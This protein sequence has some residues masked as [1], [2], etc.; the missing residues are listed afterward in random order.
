MARGGAVK[1]EASQKSH[2]RPK[3][4]FPDA[5]LSQT[6]FRIGDLNLEGSRICGAGGF[7]LGGGR[8]RK[9]NLR[10]QKYGDNA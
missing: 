9:I 5:R 1:S 3:S 10:V 8:L 6:I 4:N 2:I 7:A